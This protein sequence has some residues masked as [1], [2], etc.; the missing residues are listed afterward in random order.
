MLANTIRQKAFIWF[1]T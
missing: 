1:L